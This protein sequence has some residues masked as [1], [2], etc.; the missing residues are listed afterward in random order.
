MVENF[1]KLAP[2]LSSPFLFGEIGPTSF[3]TAF[4]KSNCCLRLPPL[5]RRSMFSS[6]LGP[7]L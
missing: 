4:E 1:V 2:L 7:I 3:Q 6:M 5:N